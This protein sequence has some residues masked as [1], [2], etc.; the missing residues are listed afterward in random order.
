MA[1]VASKDS[2]TTASLD[3]PVNS[4]GRNAVLAV[5]EHPDR[6]E[7]FFKGDRGIF[8]DVRKERDLFRSANWTLNLPVIPV[9]LNHKVFAMFKI[10]EVYDPIAEGCMVVTCG[11]SIPT[12]LDTRP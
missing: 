2:S 5:Q 8:E 4:P 3:S 1:R 7:L 11:V 12:G 6:R 9:K 10:R